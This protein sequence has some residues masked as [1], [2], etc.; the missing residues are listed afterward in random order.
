MVTI[1]VA[2]LRPRP[3]KGVEPY[4]SVIMANE[5]DALAATGLWAG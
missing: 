3:A 2:V 1:A 4:A 5:E